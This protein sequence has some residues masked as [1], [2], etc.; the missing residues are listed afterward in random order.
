[1]NHG[2]I[3]SALVPSLHAFA[4]NCFPLCALPFGPS[5][6]VLL[7]FE[8]L[9]AKNNGRSRYRTLTVRS[10]EQ[11]RVPFHVVDTEAVSIGCG[12]SKLFLFV[13]RKVESVCVG[14]VYLYLL[15]ECF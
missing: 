5:L 15:G 13:H 3:L 8:R 2:S 14:R 7:T 1:M 10:L 4:K 11:A 9:M 12:S 6:E